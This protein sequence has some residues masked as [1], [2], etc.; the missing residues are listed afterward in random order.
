M[1]L[2]CDTS[3]LVKRYVEE[4]GTESVDALWA[5]STAIATSVAAFAET[6]SAFTRK[7]REGVIS[8]KEY[9]KMVK[10]FKEDYEHLILIPIDN[11]LNIAIEKLL[12]KHPL[13]GFDAIHLASAF[14]FYD[15]LDIDF[16]FAC[17]DGALNKAAKKEGLR[18]ALEN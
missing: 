10:K 14:V 13:R 15:F 12:K 3:A 5:D 2:Y 11:D 1:I 8:S 9:S 17:F 7:Q 4:K 16:V 6:I 18:V